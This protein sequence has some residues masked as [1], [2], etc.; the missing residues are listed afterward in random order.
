MDNKRA[1]T[2]KLLSKDTAEIKIYC[3]E[4]KDDQIPNRIDAG[5]ISH[6]K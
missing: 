2:G 1:F 6:K 5:R 3:Q 4:N